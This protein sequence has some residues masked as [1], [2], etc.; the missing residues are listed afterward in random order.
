MGVAQVVQ[1]NHGN[2][3]V[4]HQSA[5]RLSDRVRLQRIADLV[6]EHPIARPRRHAEAQIPLALR[7]AMTL[8]QRHRL[9]VEIEHPTAPTGLGRRQRLD[10]IDD[11][12]GV[13]D[14]QAAATEIEVGHRNPTT[15]LR[16]MPVSA[17]RRNRASLRLPA[18]D[19]R[20]WR[21]SAGVHTVMSGAF[22]RAAVNDGALASPRH[23]AQHE[24]LALGIV[25]QLVQRGMDV[26]DRGQRE[27]GA[28]AAPGARQ[29]G[30]Q[31]VE[32]GGA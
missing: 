23:V 28:V 20:N 24:A 2:P 5:E 11:G 3:G 17:I 6:R 32:I 14:D 12:G 4:G 16:R 18:I 8:E 31:A 10:A 25:E 1:T 7:H 26:M 19:S 22:D 13:I 9:R 21:S 29:T 30:V 15:S 27:S